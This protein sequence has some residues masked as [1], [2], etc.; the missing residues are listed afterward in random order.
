[1]AA[2][3]ELIGGLI[4]QRFRLKNHNLTLLMI[5]LQWLVEGQHVGSR[6][7]GLDV[8]ILWSCAARIDSTDCDP[9][10]DDKDVSFYDHESE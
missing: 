5:E 10:A 9:L 2:R 1:M 7:D 8:A 4:R 6:V 3:A